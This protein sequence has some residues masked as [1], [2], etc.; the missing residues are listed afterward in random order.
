MMNFCSV[1]KVLS[2]LWFGM[3]SNSA[4]LQTIPVFHECAFQLKVDLVARSLFKQYT[5]LENLNTGFHIFL[6]FSF[7]F[8]PLTPNCSLVY[9]QDVVLNRIKLI[10]FNA[11]IVVGAAMVNLLTPLGENKF[12]DHIKDVILPYINLSSIGIQE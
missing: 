4:M 2:Y 1:A 6:D 8:Q 7:L 12:G 11:F 5:K 10:N 9:V 3:H